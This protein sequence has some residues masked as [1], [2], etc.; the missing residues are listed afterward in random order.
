MTFLLMIPRN[1]KVRLDK[2]C[3]KR[4]DQGYWPEHILFQP[5]NDQSL[6]ASSHGLEL[7][8]FAAFSCFHSYLKRCLEKA[9]EDNVMPSCSNFIC[10]FVFRVHPFLCYL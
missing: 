1:R 2:L 8:S 4:I 10:L 3:E 9:S 6:Q 5:A 7:N